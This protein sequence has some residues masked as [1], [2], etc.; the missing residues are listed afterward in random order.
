MVWSRGFLFVLL[1]I[2][3]G[4]EYSKAQ[5]EADDYSADTWGRQLKDLE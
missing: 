3:E 2:V 5:L 1:L 4:G